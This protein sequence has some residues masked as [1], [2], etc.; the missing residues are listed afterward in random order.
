METPRKRSPDPKY[1][2]SGQRPGSCLLRAELWEGPK[3]DPTPVR[4]SEPGEGDAGCSLSGCSGGVLP[5]QEPCGPLC[6]AGPSEAP[7]GEQ[8]PAQNQRPP[9]TSHLPRPRPRALLLHHVVPGLTSWVLAATGPATVDV[10]PP[11]PASHSSR[12]LPGFHLTPSRAH[13]CPA[14]RRRPTFSH[15]TRRSTFTPIAVSR[16]GAQASAWPALL[17][18]GPRGR[19]GPPAPEQIRP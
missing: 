9:T 12:H 18:K 19:Q 1:F 8:V 4:P 16:A 10:L 13:G 5:A 11:P 3:P 6:S 14:H 15:C 7:R 17:E 2:S